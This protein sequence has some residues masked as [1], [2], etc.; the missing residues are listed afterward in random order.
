MKRACVIGQNIAHSRSPMIHNH[1]IKQYGLDADYGIQ[2]VSSKQVADI[3]HQIRSDQLQGCNVTIPHKQ[4]VASL[5]DVIDKP[6]QLSQSINTLYMSGVKLH[7]TSTDGSGYLAHLKQTW[8]DFEVAGSTI[9][10][11]GAGGAARSIAAALLEEDVRQIHVVN[12]TLEKAETLAAMNP[13][14]MSAATQDRLTELVPGTD[15]IINTTS[16]GTGGKGEFECPLALAPAHCII[17][18]IVYVPLETPMLVR[19]RK[20]G[21]RTLDGLGMLLHQAVE[22]FERWFGVKPEVT[23]ELRK[24]LEQDIAQHD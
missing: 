21:L 4:L 14:I 18:D 2:D 20:H 8:P 15:L 11:L 19:A 13:A 24:L 23:P 3:I 16:L 7:G 17:S 5:V 1:W 12:R 10:M 22:G 6:A 9:I